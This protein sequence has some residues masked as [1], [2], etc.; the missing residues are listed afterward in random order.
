MGVNKVE[1]MKNGNPE[2]LIDLTGDTVEEDFVGEGVTFHNAEGEQKV[3]LLKIV[4]VD[5][6]LNENSENPIQNKAVAKKFSEV[7]KE[8]ADQQAAINN[9]QPKG[10][11]VLRSE[12][13]NVPVQS[14]NG[15]T[16]DVVLDAEDV[17]ATTETW[18]QAKI[19]DLKSQG[20]QQVPLFANSIEECTDKTKVYVLPD[21]YIYGLKKVTEEV[22]GETVANFTNIKDQCF[23]KYQYRY[24][25][26]NGG[27]KQASYPTYSVTSVVIP[28]PA[29]KTSVTIYIQG[30]DYGTDYSAMY[31]GN[32][33]ESFSAVDTI[34]DGEWYQRF[35]VG[36]GEYVIP[37]TKT[38]GTNGIVLQ[39]AGHQASD[40]DD[41][42]ITVDEPI[43]YIVEKETVTT[44]KFINTGLA[45][46]PADYE[47]RILDLE[48]TIVE[49]E[50]QQVTVNE[51]A[52][53]FNAVG[54]TFPPTQ[55]PAD[56]SFD[57]YDVNL[58]SVK[59][60]EIYDYIDDVVGNKETVTK[61]IMGKDASGKYD[62]IRYTYANREHIAWQK[63]NYPKMYAWNSGIS[64]ETVNIP[65][66]ANIIEGYRYSHSEQSFSKTTGSSI[67]VP[68]PK[69]TSK[70]T[71][72]LAG[73][74]GN[75]SYDGCYGG[76]TNSAFPEKLQSTSPWDSSRTTIVIPN[77]SATLDG[78]NYAIFFISQSTV[79]NAT[80]TLNDVVIPW[81][82]AIISNITASQERISTSSSSGTGDTIYS[83]SVSPRIGDTL[84]TTPYIGT[85]YGK[86]TAV[87]STK[88][89]RTVNG[90]EF[91]RYQKGDVEPTVIYTDLDDER[92]NDSSISISG[93]TYNRY[94][95]GDLGSNREKLIPI[96]IYANE[97]GVAPSDLYFSSESQMCALVL[98]RFFRDIV[99][100]KQIKN[101]LYKY[102]RE[103]C[104]LII[105]PIA[106]PFGFNMH[107]TGDT[108]ASK[109]GYQNSNNVNINRNYDTIGWDVTR[110]NESY[111]SGSYAGSENETQYIMN[112][113]VESGAKVAMSWHSA[114]W[115][116]NSHQGQ[117]PHPTIKD[118]Y[119]DYNR[120]KLNKIE[121]FMKTNYG[122]NQRYYD[123]YTQS[124]VDSGIVDSSMIG[125]PYPCKNTP[126]VTS[127]SPSFISQCGAYGGIVEFSPGD[128][129][130][131]GTLT[132]I[133]SIKTLENAYAFAMNLTA[134]FLS[135]Y[136]ENR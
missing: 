2:T 42:I 78:I 25:K 34:A 41:L 117:N 99:S 110:A 52:E 59:S 33:T 32:G 37:I 20:I 63:E 76:A 94:P 131:G 115:W 74:S 129:D 128:I 68:I 30:R 3:G 14:V 47:E 24:S 69:N 50:N 62:I 26:S 15:K 19:N 13:P 12:M 54:T 116:Y 56:S 91:V 57:G 123:L 86:V 73:V 85:E 114:E 46:V 66:K 103:N 75:S 55:K 36:E 79:S 17:G 97:H 29:D 5:S 4:S 8:I 35:S 64:N 90:T 49:L 124:E 44:E 120:D 82:K 84:Y 134:M 40:F 53:V 122:Y 45:F 136:L 107:L 135:D 109:N 38:A 1:I 71:I 133:M 60:N 31:S 27:Y 112:T 7:Q 22:E 106:N 118:E 105:I 21:G 18:V 88:R 113:M 127:K 121:K 51:D 72:K 89:S 48:R 95:L 65:A 96:F 83:K 58:Y 11:Y 132:H 93:V 100:G 130:V 102:I 81:E 23:Y 10:D 70:V 43:E 28:V 77:G 87:N 6:E 108:N 126:D 9:K 125:K 16:G 61:E 101:P 119:V 67:I 39:L 98:S 104:M 80:I 92:N 111:W